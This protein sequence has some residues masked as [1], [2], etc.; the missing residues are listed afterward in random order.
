MLFHVYYLHNK[1]GNHVDWTY[2]FSDI[3][4]DRWT[5]GVYSHHCPLEITWTSWQVL[6]KLDMDVTALATLVLF[7][8]PCNYGHIANVWGES[9]TSANGIGS[10][11]VQYVFVVNVSILSVTLT[12]MASSARINSEW[13]IGND[14]RESSR[15][16]I[17]GTAP[18][19]AQEWVR[20]ATKLASREG[21][22]PGTCSRQARRI[23]EWSSSLSNV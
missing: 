20:K 7:L 10:S 2:V 8:F 17:W 9:D 3:Y 4:K 6:T 23:T 14:A 11:Y 21:C 5:Y 16:L 12:C 18:V 15:G 1:I 19:F 13:L 22:E